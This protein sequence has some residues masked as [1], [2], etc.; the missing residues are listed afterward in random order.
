M[1]LNN[2]LHWRT[3]N[4]PRRKAFRLTLLLPHFGMC[5]CVLLPVH[6]L[7]I[8]TQVVVLEIRSRATESPVSHASVVA[9]RKESVD[10]FVT[11]GLGTFD[12][13]LEFF[14]ETPSSTDAVGNTR[15]PIPSTV[16]C[17]ALD[18]NCDRLADVVSR[19]IFIVR[20]ETGNESEI[21]TLPFIPGQQVSGTHFAVMVLT[22]G[23][24]VASNN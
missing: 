16:Y 21:V 3:T 22:V 14:S 4:V 8:N 7:F 18:F 10:H 12:E 1:R 5:G 23:P 24:P 17:P 15:L 2:A 11:D 19:H 20:I 13:A 9:F 6:H